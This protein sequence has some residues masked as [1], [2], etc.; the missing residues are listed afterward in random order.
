MGIFSL[1]LNVMIFIIFG[2]WEF[3]LTPGTTIWYIFCAFGI[4]LYLLAVY[5][6]AKVRNY[7]NIISGIILFIF[8]YYLM[9]DFYKAFVNSCWIAAIWNSVENI[10]FLAR[11]YKLSKSK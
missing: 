4:F 6:G 7:E 9:H 3:V 10:I 8:S 2:I 11:M 1:V 5:Q